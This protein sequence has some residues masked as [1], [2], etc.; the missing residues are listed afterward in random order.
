VRDEKFVYFTI[1]CEVKTLSQHSK[2]MVIHLKQ[3][4]VKRFSYLYTGE[5]SAVIVFFFISF[6]MNEIFTYLR[7]YSLYSFWASFLLLEFILAQG[8]VYWYMKWKRLKEGKSSITPNHVLHKFKQV[9]K[10]N[11][12]FILLS[13]C[14]FIL[15]LLVLESPLPLGGLLI[16]GCIYIFAIIEYI[17][18]FHIQLSYDNISDIKFLVQTKKL[19][20]A[21]LAKEL[22]R[23]M[24]SRVSSHCK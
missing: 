22:E 8:S 21:S 9:K 6:A 16:A 1:S 12:V 24:Q 14:F 23:I 13:P 3:K 5:L 7:L 4:L 15:D 17:N 10:W 11:F 2:V 20:K 18:Y 19:K